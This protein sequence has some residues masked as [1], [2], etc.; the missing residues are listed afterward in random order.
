MDSLCG[1]K[2]QQCYA[3]DLNVKKRPLLLSF[4]LIIIIIIIVVVVVVVV[5]NVVVVVAVVVVVVTV[6]F[7][8]IIIFNI[9]VRGVPS[10]PGLKTTDYKNAC[11]G[12]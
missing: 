5:V 11:T 1:G 10:S 3:L 2:S 12:Y 6:L 7:T 8:I 4:I 9:L